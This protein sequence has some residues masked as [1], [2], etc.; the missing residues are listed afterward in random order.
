MCFKDDKLVSMSFGIIFSTRGTM[1]FNG[2]FILLEFRNVTFVCIS[3]NDSVLILVC[4]VTVNGLTKRISHVKDLPST[5]D[6]I[7]FSPSVASLLMLFLSLL[8][9]LSLKCAPREFKN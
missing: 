3:D 6:L 1:M 5:I 2:Y 7:S 4:P 9:L 8:N